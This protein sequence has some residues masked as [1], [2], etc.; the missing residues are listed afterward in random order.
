MADEF[1]SM[2]MYTRRNLCPV[3]MELAFIIS[4]IF[5]PKEYYIY[6][7]FL[8]YLALAVWFLLQ[9]EFSFSDWKKNMQGGRRFWIPVFFTALGFMAAFAVTIFLEGAF[10]GLAVGMI[11]LRRNTWFTLFLFTLSTIILP[12][13]VEECFF[14][15]SMI[16]FGNK[17]ILILTSFGGMFMYAL[18][19]ALSLWGILLVMLWAL[20]LSLSYIKTKNVYIPMT[21]H[22]IVN[23]LGNGTDVVFTAAALLK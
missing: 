14:R 4:C 7:N 6:T 23:L 3:I 21:A 1:L 2:K 12:P 22:F 5:L 8:F 20:P 18:E 17:K 10:P 13:V 16:L 9:K 15:K 11:G 19:H